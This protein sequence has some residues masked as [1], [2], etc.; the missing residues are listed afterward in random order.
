MADP[1]KKAF[2]LRREKGR[3]KGISP[4]SGDEIGLIPF[5]SAAAAELN[6]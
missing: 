3:E 1:M 4:I 5:S 2:R 6:R